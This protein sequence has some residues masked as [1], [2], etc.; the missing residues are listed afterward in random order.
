MVPVIAA[1]TIVAVLVSEGW[2]WKRTL[3]ETCSS[4]ATTTQRLAI[5]QGSGSCIYRTGFGWAKGFSRRASWILL[6]P[7]PA[8]KQP[9]Y[10]GLFWL[11]ATGQW[12]LPKDAYYMSGE[13][14]KVFIVP[15]LDLVQSEPGGSETYDYNKK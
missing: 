10:G 15:S 14:G 7:A 11:N 3:T 6:E 8:W 2:S 1:V 4:L 12:N 5:G 9:I 13:G